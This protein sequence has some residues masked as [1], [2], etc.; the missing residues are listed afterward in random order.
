MEE[1]LRVVLV[2][3]RK[4]ATKA[5]LS[6]HQLARHQPTL[7]QMRDLINA[8]RKD[9]SSWMS[10]HSLD[11]YHNIREQRRNGKAR[12][13]SHSRFTTYCFQIYGCRFLLNKLIDLPIE[14]SSRY[15]RPTFERLLL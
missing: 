4:I 12:D 6:R 5:G 10:A 14:R 13:L 11:K 15:A 8:W 7:S 9:V 3:R 2:Q 1:L